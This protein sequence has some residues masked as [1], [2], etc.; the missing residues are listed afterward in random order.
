MGLKLEFGGGM[1]ALQLTLEVT[2][3]LV[4]PVVIIVI[5]AMFRKAIS[6]LIGRLNQVEGFGVKVQSDVTALAV[7]V[8]QAAVSD[9][10]EKEHADEGPSSPAVRDMSRDPEGG[11]GS[12]GGWDEAWDDRARRA[13]DAGPD[14]TEFLSAHHW[15]ALANDPSVK[16]IGLVVQAWNAIVSTLKFEAHRHGIAAKASDFRLAELL[17]RKDVLSRETLQLLDEARMVRNRAVHA[18]NPPPSSSDAA[19]YGS[20]AAMLILR[21]R[22]E[23]GSKLKSAAPEEQD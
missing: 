12:V 17:H 11:G 13:F 21:I 22:R 10:V 15:S 19:L 20:T 14:L 7:G 4:W 9:I 6:D 5:A 1:D 16:P 2:K 8:Q 23:S 3:V 18:V